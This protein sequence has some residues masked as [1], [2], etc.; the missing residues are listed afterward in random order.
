MDKIKWEHNYIEDVDLAN[1]EWV[2]IPG[3]Q[4]YDYLIKNYF[5]EN[6]EFDFELVADEGFTSNVNLVFGMNY[7]SFELINKESNYLLGIVDNNI[8]KKTIVADM[9]FED[10]FYLFKDQ[11]TPMT[12]LAYGEV[13]CFFRKQGIYKRMCEE[14]AKH[15][16]PDQHLLVTDESEMGVECET[17]RIL[18]EILIEHGFEKRVFVKNI[19]TELNCHDE[20]CANEKTI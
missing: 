1:I 11:Q 8:G 10:D 5:N 3:T 15:I 7:L 13:N 2:V 16:N 20:I 9:M 14:F 19:D 4:L 18:E 6:N 17:Q 12:F